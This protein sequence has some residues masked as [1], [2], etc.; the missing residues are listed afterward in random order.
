MK[1]MEKHPFAALR[2]DGAEIGYQKRGQ[3][4][5]KSSLRE[6]VDWVYL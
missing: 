3:T 2:G 6:K 1:H 4:L 5:P